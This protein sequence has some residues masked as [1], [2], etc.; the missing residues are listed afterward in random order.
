MCD[1]LF[2]DFVDPEHVNYH[3]QITTAAALFRPETI[4]TTNMLQAVCSV[5]W[6]QALVTEIL[7]EAK[8]DHAVIRDA[9]EVLDL[10]H[11]NSAQGLAIIAVIV[12]VALDR[13]NFSNHEL[14]RDLCVKCILNIM[15]DPDFFPDP[16]DRGY[17]VTKALDEIPITEEDLTSDFRAALEYSIE[18]KGFSWLP[19][20]P[21]RLMGQNMPMSEL[22]QLLHQM[23]ETGQFRIHEFDLDAAIH[24]IQANRDI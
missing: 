8:T 24:N 20:T 11:D 12:Q 5:P 17:W 1:I 18:T 15:Q 14:L 22:T 16:Y 21:R 4:K 7:M 10:L 19:S 9:L 2:H 3:H 23:V 6:N 13:D